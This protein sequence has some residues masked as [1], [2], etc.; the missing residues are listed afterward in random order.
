MSSMRRIAGIALA[1]MLLSAAVAYAASGELWEYTL[2]LEMQG[3]STP[4]GSGTFCRAANASLKPALPANCKLDQFSVAGNT[5]SFRAVCGPPQNSI[6][7]GKVTR[8][9]DQ[10]SGVFRVQGGGND[11]TMLQKAHKVGGCDKPVE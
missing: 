10:V 2:T 7:S 9:G 3:M 11:V 5:S 6:M 4:M 1:A 8:T